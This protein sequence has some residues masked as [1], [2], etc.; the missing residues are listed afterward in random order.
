[1]FRIRNKRKLE[2][3]FSRSIE[4]LAYASSHFFFSSNE[5]DWIDQKN[6]MNFSK[7]RQREKIVFFLNFI[8]FYV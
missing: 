8:H 4:R 5:L 3:N 1:M 6:L 7:N 2:M